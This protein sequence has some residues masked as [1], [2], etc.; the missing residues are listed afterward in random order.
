MKFTIDAADLAS[1]LPVAASTAQAGSSSAQ[2]LGCVLIEASDGGVVKLTSTDYD[3]VSVTTRTAEVEEVGKTAIPVKSLSD[4]F[5]ALSGAVHVEVIDNARAVIRC[6]LIKYTIPVLPAD[7]FPDSRSPVPGAAFTFPASLLSKMIEATVCAASDDNARANLNGC[8]FEIE[9]VDGEVSV[10]ITATDGHR[11]H[12]TRALGGVALGTWKH[13]AFAGLVATK[14]LDS[15]VK[16]L[17]GEGTVTVE[18]S[19]ETTTF[20][21]GS[22][23]LSGR[24]PDET[25]PNYHAVIPKGAPA[26]TV[27]LRASELVKAVKAVSFTANNKTKLVRMVVS[28]AGIKVCSES[29]DTGASVVEVP[30]EVN[31]PGLEVGVSYPYMLDAVKSA[32]SETVRILFRDQFSPVVVKGND[33]D[34]TLCLVMPMRI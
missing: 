16:L 31:G 9:R 17:D 8:N 25:Y 11:M 7:D 4:A 10:R 1:A 22:T 26:C 6:G 30:C 14:T 34:E 18:W 28:E 19:A 27:E 32:G 13:P 20:T 2:I 29:P 23:D 33:D 21:A 5:K 3:A 15:A 12:T 24:R